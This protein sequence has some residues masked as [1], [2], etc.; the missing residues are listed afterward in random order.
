VKVDNMSSRSKPVK[1]E[2]SR[3]SRGDVDR[4]KMSRLVDFLRA[5]RREESA[6]LAE[7][8]FALVS[9]HLVRAARLL[10]IVMPNIDMDKFATMAAAE[11]S[12]MSRGAGISVF[13]EVSKSPLQIALSS[14]YG[15]FDR[16]GEGLDR[17]RVERKTVLVVSGDPDLELKGP[18]RSRRGGRR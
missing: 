11:W 3:A 14:L 15:K 17:R 1:N 7:E 18:K 2:V 12:R 9:R 10:M 5:R 4:E 6:R 8:L 13:N 16:L